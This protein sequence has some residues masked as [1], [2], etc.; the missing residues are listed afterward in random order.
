MNGDNT[1]RDDKE[2]KSLQ[3][4]PPDAEIKESQ[5][6]DAVIQPEAEYEI[7]RLYKLYKWLI[8][9]RI[10]LLDAISSDYL[11]KFGMPQA[12][13]WITSPRFWINFLIFFV[14][15][16]TFLQLL[17]PETSLWSKPEPSFCDFSLNDPN[18]KYF[19]QFKENL[20][21]L[22]F[23]LGDIKEFTIAP[24]A[25]KFLKAHD[26]DKTY[27]VICIRREDQRG[28]RMLINDTE[29]WRLSRVF[30][31]IKTITVF[32]IVQYW[33][34][35]DHTNDQGASSIKVP[36]F[37]KALNR[38]LFGNEKLDTSQNDNIMVNQNIPLAIE[39]GATWIEINLAKIKSNK[40][41]NLKITLEPFVMSEF[42]SDWLII[43]FALLIPLAYFLAKAYV[44]Y[45]KGVSSIKLPEK[46][47]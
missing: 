28:A 36:F 14:S 18:V 2:L 43:N 46:Q 19:P 26:G 13:T 4:E 35:K 22:D 30:K 5:R 34:S 17:S 1:Q 42:W 10:P 31:A 21:T 6:S 8:S 33:F 38:K 32:G 39:R 25:D 40:I 11:E 16:F 23:K 7:T 20:D 24:D 44:K 12:I 47:T 37:T 29:F 45:L 3:I 27:E 9:K 15:L 41:F